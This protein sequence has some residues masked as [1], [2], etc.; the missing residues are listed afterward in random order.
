MSNVEK[1]QILRKNFDE[2]FP[3]GMDERQLWWITK[4]AK[5]VRKFARTNVAYNNL[6]NALFEGKAVFKDV[7]KFDSVKQKSYTGLSITVKGKDGTDIT[8]SGKDEGDE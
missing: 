4:F 6:C 2:V 8:Y 5:T 1:A 3:D 7:N